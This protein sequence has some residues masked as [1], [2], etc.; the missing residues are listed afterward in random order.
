MSKEI[1]RFERAWGIYNDSHQDVFVDGTPVSPI[2]ECGDKVGRCRRESLN[3]FQVRLIE[4]GK[5][6]ASAIVIT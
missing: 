6:D 1:V 5:F 2:P 3:E 4:L